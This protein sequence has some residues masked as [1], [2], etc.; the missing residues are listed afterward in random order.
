MPIGSPQHSTF[1]P[2]ERCYASQDQDHKGV[3]FPSYSCII[4]ALVE[5]KN[6]T[7]NQARYVV[8]KIE[9]KLIIFNI[10]VLTNSTSSYIIHLFRSL[11]GRVYK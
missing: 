6:D 9:R 11:K 7:H 3:V 4:F 5:H 8:V 2:P 1:T 10:Y